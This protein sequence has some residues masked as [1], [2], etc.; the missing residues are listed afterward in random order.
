MDYRVND[1]IRFECGLSLNASKVYSALLEANNVL[2]SLPAQLFRSIDYKTTSATVGCIFCESVVKQTD[3]YAIVNPIEK[4]HP[5]IIPVKARYCSEEELRN[6]PEGLEVKC[7]IASV[8]KGVII[9]K[10]TPRI[11]YIN[12]IVW[13]AHHREVTE[14]LGLTYDY[15]PFLDSY[16][17]Q[18]SGLFYSSDLT[19][20]DWGR[21]SGTN[22]R[23][24][25]VCAMLASGLYKMGKGW[26][27]IRNERKYL[28]TYAK[29]FRIQYN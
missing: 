24:T 27:A 12:K 23:N 29:I 11:D 18:I 28:D 22:G 20:D 10:A 13:Q 14:L 9:D 5:D 8:P 4:G 2:Q 6:Y 25:K 7:T 3:R 15:F 19:E 26:V 21:I 1:R 16:V 17:P